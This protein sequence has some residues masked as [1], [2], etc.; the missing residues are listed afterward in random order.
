M[1]PARR[2]AVLR[3]LRQLDGLNDAERN[4]K[5]NDPKFLR[6]LKPEERQ[7]MPYLSRLR[8]GAEP[9]TEPPPGF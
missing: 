4:A 2:Q 3:H 9:E 1:P 6:G 7:M 5:L 8:V